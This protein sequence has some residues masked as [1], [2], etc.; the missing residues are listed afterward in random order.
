MASFG[1]DSGLDWKIWF[2]GFAALVLGIALLLN[3][4]MKATPQAELATD[5]VDQS[6]QSHTDK[7]RQAA[8]VL[9][10]VLKGK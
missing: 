8:D 4:D 9:S 3:R 10:S 2:V 5:H 6:M 7:N 1:T